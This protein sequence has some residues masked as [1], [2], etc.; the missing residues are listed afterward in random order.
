MLLYEEDNTMARINDIPVIEK[1]KKD[2]KMSGSIWDKENWLYIPSSYYDM[3][4]LQPILVKIPKEIC[5]Q[6]VKDL[7]EEIFKEQAGEVMD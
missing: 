3:I 4:E 2:D 1:I 7:M 5:K 6:M